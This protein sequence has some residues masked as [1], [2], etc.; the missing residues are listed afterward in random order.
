[1]DLEYYLYLTKGKGAS[2]CTIHF[3][4]GRIEEGVYLGESPNINDLG[5]V[6]RMTGETRKTY[7]HIGISDPNPNFV[8]GDTLEIKDN[9]IGIRI[10]SIESI[11][12]KN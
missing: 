1:M 11:E 5:M 2:P 8:S 3:K 4:D 12:F 9:K 7:E 6:I 10:S